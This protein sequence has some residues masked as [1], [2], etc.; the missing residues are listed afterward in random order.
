MSVNYFQSKLKL[1][2]S[3]AKI[4]K[5]HRERQKKSVS[6]ISAE[7]MLTKSIWSDLEKG[8]KDPQISTLWRI[9]E[10]LNITLEDLIS[11]IRNDLG[12]EFTLID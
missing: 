2:K 9:S 10:A 7:I 8:I 12:K 4:V 6:R 5:T 3:I 1:Q 11:E